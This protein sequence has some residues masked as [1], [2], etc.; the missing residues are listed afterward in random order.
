MITLKEISQIAGVSISTVSKALSGAHDI[1]DESRK[2][3]QE[4]ADSHG[5]VA[6]KGRRRKE[7]N[8][9]PILAIIYPDMTSS[10]FTHLL[11]CFDKQ[12]RAKNGT[13]VMGCSR[14]DIDIERKLL[15]H[16]MESDAVDGIVCITPFNQ[17]DSMPKRGVPVVVISQTN[18]EFS[19][20]DTIKVNDRQGIFQTIERLKFLGHKKIGYIGEKNTYSRLNYFKEAMKYHS[21]EIDESLIKVSPHRFEYA[22]YDSMNQLI[23]ENNLPT[24]LFASYDDIAVGIARALYEKNIRIPEDI[25]LVGIDNT[26][27]SLYLKDRLSSIGCHIEEQV[28]IALN[29]LFN[30]INNP[31][32]TVVQNITIQTELIAR[33]TL[34]PPKE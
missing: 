31:Q 22:G 9:Q 12:L 5:Y 18:L 32:F 26:A 10:Y 14:F 20:V 1:G 15:E 27:S 28:Q 8:E 30:K 6:P 24:A 16:F 17:I 4:I 29:T 21:C 19:S 23:S 25:S 7:A 3:I 33:D 13:L 2:R 34:A 11:D